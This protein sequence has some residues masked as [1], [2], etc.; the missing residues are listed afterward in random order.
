M[1][2]VIEQEKRKIN[3]FSLAS[4]LLLVVVIGVSIYY[5]FFASTPLVEKVAPA[6]LQSIQELSLIKLQPEAVISSPYFQV[7]KQYV[8]PIEIQSGAVGKINPFAR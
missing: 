4:V 1:A 5:L 3:W 6:R 7:L 2:I 8:N